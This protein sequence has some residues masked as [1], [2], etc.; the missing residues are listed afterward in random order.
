ML[1]RQPQESIQISN[2]ELNLRRLLAGLMV[3]LGITTALLAGCG[4]VEI[5]IEH[6]SPA[7]AS[8]RI[9]GSST[10]EAQPTVLNQAA[11]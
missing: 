1:A 10:G 4:S 8:E 3:G 11:E 2:R 5:G 9:G 6:V 7:T